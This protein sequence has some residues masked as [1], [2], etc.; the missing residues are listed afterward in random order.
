VVSTMLWLFGVGIFSSSSASDRAGGEVGV[1]GGFVG[2]L[3]PGGVF[4]LI[5]EGGTIS[6]ICKSLG[7]VSGERRVFQYFLFF[8]CCAA[9]VAVAVEVGGYGRWE[10]GEGDVAERQPSSSVVGS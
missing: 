9:A 2:A 7:E 10:L 1:I 3:F 8:S 5:G 6:D 4:P